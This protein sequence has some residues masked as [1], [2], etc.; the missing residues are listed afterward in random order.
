MCR[1]MRICADNARFSIT[2]ITAAK[3]GLGYGYEHIRKLTGLVV[4]S[5][6]KKNFF[7]A[8]HFNAEEAQQIGLS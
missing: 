6:A 5:R 7:A 8:Q 3:L 1:D 2:S 4:P